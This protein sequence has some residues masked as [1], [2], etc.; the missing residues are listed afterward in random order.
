MTPEERKMY[1]RRLW[2]GW[3]LLRSLTLFLMDEHRR[4]TLKENL[5]SIREARSLSMA[6]DMSHAELLEEKAEKLCDRPLLYFKDQVFSYRDMNLNANRVGNFLA[7]MGGGPGR[8]LAIIMRNS[9][10]WLDVFFGLEKIGMY[11]VPV[12]IALR[13]DQLAYVIDNSDAEFVVIDHDLLPIYR[14]VEDKLDKIQRVIVNTRGAPDDFVLPTG[15]MSLDDAYGPGSDASTPAVD[16]DPGDLCV[17]MYT[18]GTTGLP[19]GVV[20]RYEN[21]N[22]KAISVVG[23]LLT[24]KKDVAY[25]CYPLFHANALFL[26]V[27]PTL[28]CEGSMALGERFSA[29]RFWDDIRRYGVTT[30]NGLGAVMP[31]LMKQPERAEDADNEV[32]FILSAGCPADMWRAFE[33]RFGLEIF[34]GYGAVDGGGVLLVNFGTAPVGS[35]GKPLGARVRV[36]DAGGGDVPAGTPGELIAYVGERKGSVE[37]YKNPEATSDKMRDGWLYTGDLVYTDEMGYIYFVG[38]NTES[39][40]VKGENVSAYEVE[41]AVLQHSDILECAVF[42]VPSELAEDDIMV[43]LVPVEGKEVDPSTLPAFLS[44]KLAKFAIPR[45]FR[46]MEELPKTETHRVIKSELEKAGVAPDAYDAERKE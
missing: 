39:M 41:Q 45:Y 24:G 21:S 31:I 8:G 35:M 44:D 46:V 10:R 29:S 26:T 37:Y 20:Y 4:G 38:R 5:R 1:M 25:T 23:R 9:P 33:D 16:Y 11:T 6:R 43:T 27:T 3:R 40:R 7:G 19:K 22:V 12:N 15:V 32:R 2:L 13:A 17:I 18:S 34:E 30:F 42:A 36:I 14:A 28:H